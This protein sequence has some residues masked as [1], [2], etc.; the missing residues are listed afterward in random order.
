[1]SSAEEWAFPSCPAPPDWTLDWPALVGRFPWLRAM[2]GCP[3]DAVFHAEGDVL[4]HTRLV[5]EALSRSEAWRAL[6]GQERSITFAAALLHDVGKPS[7]TVQEADGAITSRGHARRGAEMARQILWQ[8]PDLDGPISFADREAI[9]ALVRY[10]GLPLWALE[11]RDP[12]RRVILTSQTVR[13][14]WLGQIAA[15]DVAGRHCQDAVELE[16]RL[17]LFDE[18]CREQGCLN[19]PWPFPSAHSRFVY[20]RSE[21][22][23]PQRLVY[24][25]TR[26]E[27]VL[28]SGLPGS[29]KD[30]WIAAHLP[31]WPVVSLDLIRQ[32]LGVAPE[33]DQ[34]AVVAAAKEEARVL[35][36]AQRSFVWNATNTTHMM[37]RKLVDFFVAYGARVRIVYVETTFAELLRRNRARARPVPEAVLRRLAARLDV[38]DVTE[39]DQVEWVLT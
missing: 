29:G 5:V 14:R 2:A 12:R 33:K 11:D 7:C 8:A 32:S 38:P 9:V 20:G 26:F 17:A 34:G 35:M 4:T 13:C 36:R 3:Q 27:V 21:H 31:N 19:A 24:D 18:L 22:G 1:M 23:D 37:R 30:T 16:A 10:H 28:M 25:D 15:A 39:A 6:P